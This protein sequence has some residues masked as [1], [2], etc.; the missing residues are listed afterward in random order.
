MGRGQEPQVS[1]DTGG[2]S[3]NRHA[4]SPWSELGQKSPLPPP[5]RAQPLPEGQGGLPVPTPLPSQLAHPKI[6]TET[7]HRTR[8]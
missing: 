2:P 7:M 4:G 3:W 8:G 1:E 6:C 5:G